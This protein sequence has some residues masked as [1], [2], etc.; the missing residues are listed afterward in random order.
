M[1]VSKLA[2]FQK[3]CKIVGTV[4]CVFLQ[5]WNIEIHEPTQF[6]VVIGFDPFGISLMK[7]KLIKDT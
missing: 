4:V 2:P 6:F 1:D 7:G 5:L 3:M